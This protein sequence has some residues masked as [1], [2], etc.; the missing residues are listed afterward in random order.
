MSASVPRVFLLSPASCRGKR[1]SLLLS[2]RSAFPLAEAFRRGDASLGEVFSF[3][4]GLYF[5]GKLQYARTFARPAPGGPGVLI[6]TPSEGLRPPDEPIGL[7]RLRAFAAH[8]IDAGNPLFTEPFRRDA[9]A[10]RARHPETEVVLL[11]SIATLK[12]AS[13]LS[14]VFG[15]RLVFPSAFIGRGD[16]SRGG[17]LLRH[18]RSGSE[19]DYRTLGAGPLTGVRPPRLGRV[20]STEGLVRTGT[21]NRRTKK[22]GRPRPVSRESRGSGNSGDGPA[23]EEPEDEEDGEREQEQDRKELR[24]GD[25][26]A[27]NRRE[28]E[29]RRNQSDHEKRQREFQ[30][31][32]LLPPPL[33]IQCQRAL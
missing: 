13:V 2:P 15:A 4:S 32:S 19:L 3:L 5:R 16:M 7:A 31:V 8:D 6:V 30:H 25:R 23:R 29:Q 21:R 1:A 12:Y 22:A 9:S 27:R 24:D 28:P 26:G 11:G 33:P 14:D 20:R 17:L 18:A 10:L